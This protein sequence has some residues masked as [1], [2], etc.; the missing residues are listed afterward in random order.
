[1]KRNTLLAI[2][3]FVLATP[4]LSGQSR[5]ENRNNFYEAESWILYEDFGEALPLYLRLAT[6]YPN[7]YNFKYRIGQCYINIPGEKDQAVTYLE[8]AV[9]NINLEYKEGNFK[10]LGAPFDAYYHLANAYRIH[11]EI[12]KAIETYEYFKANMNTTIYDSAI[13]NNEIQG[14]L[15][16]KVL[17]TSPLYIR[18][19]NLGI[20][21]NDDNSESYPV[22]SPDETMIIYSK[23]LAFYDAI[24]Y[25]TKVNG[26]WA[27][28]MNLNEM[29]MV[30]N[31]LYPTSISSDGKELYLYSTSNYD[32]IIYVSRLENGI[33]GPITPLNDNIN[34]KYWES[35]AT[36]SKDNK[37]LYFT[38]NR[39]DTYGGLD[40]YVSTRDIITGDWGP[41]VNLGPVI[42]TPYNEESPA[43]SEDN[44]TL[45]FSSRGHNNIGGYDIFSSK[46]VNG[47]WSAPTNIGYPLN[48]ADDDLFF[49]P[50]GEGYEGYYAKELASG[51]GG[52]DIYKIEVFSDAN[53]R[54]FTVSGKARL[55][56]QDKL[57]NDSIKITAIKVTDLNNPGNLVEVYTDPKTGEYE[58]YLP[59]GEY[60]ITFET[61]NGETVKRKLELALDDPSDQHDL[62]EVFV[63][64]TDFKADLLIDSEMEI[65][66]MGEDTVYIPLTVE[67]NSILTVDQYLNGELIKTEEF[68]VTDPLFVYKYVPPE[69]E[70]RLSFKSTD[71][72]GNV[73]TTD[74]AIAREKQEEPSMA[75]II[76]IEIIEEVIPQYLTERQLTYTE[77]EIRAFIEGANIDSMKFSSLDEQFEYLKEMASGQDVDPEQIDR[78]A[79]SI[80]VND[81][82]LTQTSVDILEKYAEGELK[83]ILAGINVEEL[84][85][86]TWDDLLEYISKESD[87][88]IT[89]AQVNDLAKKIIRSGTRVGRLQEKILAFSSIQKELDLFMSAIETVDAMGI[90]ETDKWLKAFYEE[91]RRLGATDQ[92]I[93]AMLTALTSKKGDDLES[94]YDELIGYSGINMSTWLGTIDK[95]ASGINIPEDL[96]KHILV[97]REN[98]KINLDELFVPFAKLIE[99]KDFEATTIEENAKALRGSG[100]LWILWMLLVIGGA[101]FW[102]VK[103]EKLI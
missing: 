67:P 54:K 17:M 103:K 1:M 25:S 94:Y 49:V 28:P 81:N 52:K 5:I 87:G 97:G 31:D 102:W 72:Y 27:N 61:E 32:G 16:A 82:I 15:N 35:H 65:Q 98:A 91:V 90:K 26:E 48:T 101:L 66:V 51:Y 8:E 10:E 60:E 37:K 22:V 44:T 43:L 86:E 50:I 13:I 29:L 21:I 53:P 58:F 20:N 7:N 84:G 30:D 69:G 78:L 34:S 41:A 68:R 36:I 99:S 74:I 46:L 70:S 39:K 45:F 75:D 33:W 23:S 19:K 42:N 100:N 88:E 64:L 12:D 56:N 95:T 93:A 4:L 9:K 73:A 79:L 18:E 80:S 92:Q 14:C 77:D 11:D 57:F 24:L 85:L 6:I 2:T 47:Q 83:D 71:K 76:D 3:I 55:R 59:Q 40:I 38:S 63:P 62:E 89:E 96:V